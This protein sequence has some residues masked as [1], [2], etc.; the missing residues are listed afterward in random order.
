MV[1]NAVDHLHLSNRLSGRINNFDV[2]RYFA[3]VLVIYSHSYPLTG[4]SIEPLALLSKGQWTFGGVAVAIFFVIS[5]FLVSN[6][7][8]RSTVLQ[9]TVNRFLR[10]FPGLFMAVL[11]SVFVLGPLFTSLEI[12][13]YFSNNLTYSY[14]N[15]SL[16]LSV[17]Y[18]LPGM[19][20]TNLYPN[21]V[22]GS[23]W[24]IPYE[25]LGY[26]LV[27]IIG[28]YGLLKKKKVSY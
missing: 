12:S 18:V 4:K 23:I 2:L 6:S 26:I 17:Q 5:G 25:I 20:E 10:I 13:E 28:Y 14:L 21:A 19:F 24:T 7:F 11:L 27:A 9:Y 3:A 22:N 16:L 1:D 15:N 8:E